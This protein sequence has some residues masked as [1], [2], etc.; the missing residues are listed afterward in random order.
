[1][2]FGHGGAMTVITYKNGVFAC[3]TLWTEGGLNATYA[4]KVVKLRSGAL[5]GSAGDCDDR[6]LVALLQNVKTAAKLPSRK[7]LLA[8]EADLSGLLLLPNGELWNI[9]TAKDD[10][11]VYLVVAPCAAIGAGFEVAMGAMHAGATARQAAEI[12]CRLVKTCGGPVLTFTMDG[13]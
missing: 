6:E 10:C 3:D 7:T 13:K 1:M 2:G 9:N 12:A 11:G 8:L 4:P 5:F